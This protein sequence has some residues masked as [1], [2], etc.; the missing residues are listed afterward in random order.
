MSEVDR[1]E[2]DKLAGEVAELQKICGRLVRE[3][4]DLRDRVM[5]LGARATNSAALV[6]VSPGGLTVGAPAS[7]DGVSRRRLLGKALG[8]AAVTVVGSAVLVDREARPAS[9]SD[10]ANVVAGAVT[11]AETRTSVLYDGAAGYAGVVLLGND[12]TYNGASGNYP[13]G[14]GGWAGAGSTAGKG[15]VANGVYGY[16]DNGDGNGVVGY[17]SGAVAGSGAGVLG[18]AFGAKNTAVQAH[19]TLGTAVSGT[20]DSTASDATAIV[21]VISSTSPG[22]FSAAVRGQNNGTS[23]LGIGVSAS[24]V[25]SGW[26]VYATSVSGIGVNA[27]GGTGTGLNAA[28]ATGISAQGTVLGVTASGPTAVKARGTTI[29]LDVSGPTGVAATGTTVGVTASGPTGVAATGTTIG[30]TASGP[31]G[32]TATGTTIGVTASGPTGVAATGTTIGVTAS[33]P[34]GVAATGTTVGV[35]ASGPTG[36]AATGTTIGVTASGPTAV[37]AAGTVVGL[38]ASGRTAVS[39]TATGGVAV[40]VAATATSAAATVHA[41]NT[42]KGPALRAITGGGSGV[43]AT[44]CIVGDSKNGTGVL[45]LSDGLTGVQGYSKAGR[46]GVFAGAKAQIQLKQGSLE[47]H[48]TTGETGDFFCDKTGRLWFCKKGGATAIW[49]QIA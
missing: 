29:G 23:G 44:A 12:S 26:A 31:T 16:T 4:E 20:S 39:A 19:N 40:A 21:G 6:A 8:A 13:A 2:V 11:T 45:G 18:L 25:G 5:T 46:G 41:T 9:A 33:G 14:L 17:N 30:V 37:T 10:G 22:G 42:G 49:K 48:P 34:T 15:G 47:S 43:N 3:N 7:A 24:H 38:S 28:G 1:A 27:S 35:T 36:V 32:V